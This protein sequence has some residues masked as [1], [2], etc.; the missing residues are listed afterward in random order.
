MRQGHNVFIARVDSIH[1]ECQNPCPAKFIAATLFGEHTHLKSISFERCYG[2]QVLRVRS[3]IP[4]CILTDW[5]LSYQ[6]ER[7]HGSEKSR[8]KVTRAFD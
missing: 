6:S 1:S 3:R 4:F 7:L 5:P 8:I 2:A